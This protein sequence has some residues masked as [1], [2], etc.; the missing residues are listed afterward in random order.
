MEKFFEE[1]KKNSL[2]FIKSYQI[3]QNITEMMPEDEEYEEYSKEDIEL[4]N[5]MIFQKAPRKDY[6]SNVSVGQIRIVRHTD[7]PTYVL[8]FGKWGD[9]KFLVMPFS[10]YE[11]PATHEEFYSEYNGGLY[12]QVLQ[13][14]NARSLH[15]N[16]ISKSWYCDDAGEQDIEDARTM[17]LFTMGQAKPDDRLLKKTGLPIYKSNDPR[18]QY[19]DEELENFARLDAEDF[20]ISTQFCD[21]ILNSAIRL[22]QMDEENYSMAAADEWQ[23]QSVKLKLENSDIVIIIEYSAA[24]KQLFAYVVF[25]NQASTLL[26]GWQ[27]TDKYGHELGIFM[28]GFA[29]AELPDGFDGICALLDKNDI[30]HNLEV[31]G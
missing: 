9:D 8:V 10:H 12:M 3:T 23:N 31:I 13:A 6:D 15:V 2:E 22:F 4:Q 16:S 18:L 7:K 27:I 29:K 14:W 1:R 26:D 25:D 11:E 17:W 21:N 24:E 28:D 30:S 20:E 19:K 5:N